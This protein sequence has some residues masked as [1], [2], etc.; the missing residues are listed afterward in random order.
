VKL[1]TLLL[2]V[3]NS[4]TQIQ[5][6]N[7]TIDYTTWV[8]AVATLALVGVTI[9]Y[10]I[11]TREMVKAQMKSVDAMKKSTDAQLKS[12]DAIRESTQAGFRPYIQI[13]LDFRNTQIP[14]ICLFNA[15]KGTAKS[16]ELLYKIKELENSNNKHK[17]NVLFSG[18]SR[19]IYLEL[20]GYKKNRNTEWYK[21]NQ[22]TLEIE[23]KCE[24]I[25]KNKFKDSDEI[26]VSALIRQRQNEYGG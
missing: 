17:I 10:A 18:H 19:N 22:T 11:Q 1:E 15:G 26:D 25:L 7:N 12:V 4:T 14:L 13:E 24:D 21:D 6:G 20:E 8:I 2:Q 23:W 9:F 16:I 5:G 3:S